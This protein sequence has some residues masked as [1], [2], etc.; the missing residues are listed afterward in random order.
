M[1]HSFGRIG[2]LRVGRPPRSQSSYRHVVFFAVQIP[3]ILLVL[4]SFAWR[5]MAFFL[6]WAVE[7]WACEKRGPRGAVCVSRLMW[8]KGLLWL[9]S[10]GKM[11]VVPAPSGSEG[12]GGGICAMRGRATGRLC[13]VIRGVVSDA[14]SCLFNGVICDLPFNVVGLPNRRLSTL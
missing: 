7:D 9:I 3:F 11:P 14:V 12:G 1:A 4:P 5:T 6:S 13:V 2:L 10:T 8:L